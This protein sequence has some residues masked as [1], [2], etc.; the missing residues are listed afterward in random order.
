MEE[1]IVVATNQLDGLHVETLHNLDCAHSTDVASLKEYLI[2][3][4]GLCELRCSKWLQ[5]WVQFGP[6]QHQFVIGFMQGDTCFLT[7]YFIAVNR[8]TGSVGR[9]WVGTLVRGA[10]TKVI[11]STE[12]LLDFEGDIAQHN[13]PDLMTR[14][15]FCREFHF[16]T[17]RRQDL[18]RDSYQKFS[19]PQIR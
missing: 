18:L 13:S 8:E 9:D 2:E 10:V 7:P 1:Q 11:L 12:G 19:A 6:M 15:G 4:F 16:Q 5:I 17:N 3:L 14:A